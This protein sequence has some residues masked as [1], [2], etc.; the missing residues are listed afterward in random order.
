MMFF[1]YVNLNNG[2]LM[3]YD[4]N[5]IFVVVIECIEVLKDGVLVVYGFD[6]IVGVI[7]FIMK[8]DY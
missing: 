4:F 1:V 2:M 3:F 6:V 8:N 7:N 5:L